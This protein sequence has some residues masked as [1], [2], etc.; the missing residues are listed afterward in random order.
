MPDM[1]ETGKYSKKVPQIF[2]NGEIFSSSS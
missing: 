1:V 2:Y